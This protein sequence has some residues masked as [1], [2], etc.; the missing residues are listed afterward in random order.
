MSA[1]YEHLGYTPPATGGVP[2]TDVIFLP[3]LP[4]KVIAV[5]GAKASSPASHSLSLPRAG[6]WR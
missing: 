5:N 3:S 4:A 2:M 6:R 1:Y